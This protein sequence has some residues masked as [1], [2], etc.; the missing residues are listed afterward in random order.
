MYSE[1]WTPV[2]CVGAELMIMNMIFW[3]VY[4]CIWNGAEMFTMQMYSEECMPVF[5]R[6]S[7]CWQCIY[8]LNSACLYF[9]WG[10]KVY[11][12]DTSW[13]VQAC[14]LYG[15][16]NV[17]SAYVAELCMSVSCGGAKLW[18]VEMYSGVNVHAFICMY[19][20]QLGKQTGLKASQAGG[21]I[22][23]VV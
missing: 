3:R 23:A 17:D 1:E 9:E 15:G 5:V 20:A 10:R 11:S 12:A 14:I 16:R 8:I 6:G 13:R 19:G 4:V 21:P 18:T 7:K 2:S 22:V